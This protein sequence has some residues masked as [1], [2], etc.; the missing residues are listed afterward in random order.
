MNR[1][2]AQ[3][4]VFKKDSRWSVCL[5]K[6][7]DSDAPLGGPLQLTTGAASTKRHP[8]PA[9]PDAAAWAPQNRRSQRPRVS[10]CTRVPAS[11]GVAHSALRMPS[12][13]R[14]LRLSEDQGPPGTKL[15]PGMAC[16]MPAP[17][18]S[19]QEPAAGSAHRPTGPHR[20]WMLRTGA[21]V[22]SDTHSMLTTC[23]TC[24]PP[25]TVGSTGLVC[26]LRCA[27]VKE[28]MPTSGKRA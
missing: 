2:A 10:A 20:N 5:E 21:S 28:A 11:T 13:G 3:H 24:A 17:P 14:T 27:G 8:D 15:C 4:A 9:G 6:G 18:S 7:L 26:K 25:S 22:K 19:R 16:V 1:A 12:E 23:C